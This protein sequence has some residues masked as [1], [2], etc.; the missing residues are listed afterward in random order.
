MKHTLV[1]CEG[2]GKPIHAIVN[3]GFIPRFHNAY[4]RKLWKRREARRAARLSK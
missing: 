2:C 1:V 4:C 3:S